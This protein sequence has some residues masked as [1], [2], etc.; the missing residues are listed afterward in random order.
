MRSLILATTAALALTACGRE[1]A[2]EKTEGAASV[3]GS[4]DQP[5]VAQAAAAPTMQT[6][7]RT[8]RDWR[9][10]C[11]NGNACVV[12]AGGDGGWLRVALQPGPGQVPEIR[13]GSW[14][15]G[16][17]G[18]ESPGLNLMVDGRRQEV[19]AGPA[20][21]ANAPDHADRMRRLVSVI[22]QAKTI[23]LSSGSQTEAIPATGAAAAFLWIDERQ[24]RLETTSA[25]IRRGARP[26]SA[27]PAAPPLPRVTPA[28]A[29]DQGAF[30]GADNPME[31]EPP[32]V[33]VPASL[34]SRADVRECRAEG[35][36]TLNAAI[37][38]VKLSA[39]TELWGIPCGSGA[40]NAT[41]KLFLTGLNGANPRPAALPEREPRQEGDISGEGAWLVNPI[42]DTAAQT[43]TVFP[44]GRGLGDCGTIT[45]WTWTGTAFALTE[46]RSMGDCW[47]MGPDHWPTYWRTRRE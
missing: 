28:R 7:S 5:A 25:L 39:N 37:L 2:P 22:A 4:P 23:A 45:S 3:A 32:K 31:N 11:D 41:Y 1:P 38:A 35:N 40:Y 18:D 34:E 17:I 29:V 10:V 12:W 9:V 8:F 26:D 15:L 19:R 24:G 16:E 47:G 20:N 13:T 43:L 27:V 14:A 44:R 33:A 46:E 21:A 36:Q 42:Y 30:R 6:Q